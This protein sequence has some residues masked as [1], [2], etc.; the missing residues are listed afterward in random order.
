V[1]RADFFVNCPKFKA[2]PWTTVT[3]SI[4]AYIGLQDD[5]HRLIDHDHRYGMTYTLPFR[6]LPDLAGKSKE[7][8]EFLETSWGRDADYQDKLLALQ[9]ALCVTLFGISPRYQ[10]AILL[11]GV[12]QSGK[13]QLLKIA[14]CLVPENASSFVPP[15]DWA[16]KFMPAQMHGKLINVC[17]ELSQKK[18]ID[19]QQFKD[20][21][22]GTER[23]A[24][25]KGSQIFKFK[26]VCA[27]WFASNHNPRTEDTSDGFN[28]RWLFL[29]FNYPVSLEKRKT[30]LGDVIVA[31]E[32]EAIVA[33]AVKA[34][35]R[36]KE[37]RDFTL[38]SSHRQSIREVAQAN[39][40]VR[41]FMEESRVVAFGSSV[42]GRTSEMK[43]Y[44]EYWSFCLG[45]GGVRPASSKNF[46][47]MMRELQNSLQFTVVIQPTELGAQDVY[48][49]SVIVVE[50]R[51][52]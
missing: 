40:S 14:Q 46:R 23:S 29:E 2:H 20:M 17:G 19:G 6:Y 15:H 26:P 50:Q 21:M 41:F 42:T 30:D 1:A 16:D 22:D 52:K 48:Y 49:Q 18:L 31:E 10:R 13:S 7:F 45:P 4:K 33:W 35:A 37:K 28:R 32:R 51:K 39:N 44:K 8:F 34:L 38:P 11:K 9:E 3:F 27:H 5:R 12:P 47:S 36:L 24:Q 25:F 43:L